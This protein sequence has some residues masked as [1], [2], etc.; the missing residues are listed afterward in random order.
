MYVAAGFGTVILLLISIVVLW[1][2]N[3]HIREQHFQRS[4]QHASEYRAVSAMIY[5]AHLRAIT[6]YKMTTLRDPFEVDETY[7]EFQ[8]WG[9]NL[10]K[11]RDFL[12]SSTFD[13]EEKAIWDKVRG[14]LNRGYES[15]YQVI[16]LINSGDFIAASNLISSRVSPIQDELQSKLDELLAVKT[17]RLAQAK[18]KS[19]ALD[20]T[21]D[22][23]IYLLSLTCVALCILTVIFTRRTANTEMALAAQGYR[24]RSLYE[25]ASHSRAS[26]D[27]QIDGTLRV[28][29]ELFGL[30]IGKLCKIDENTQRNKMINVVVPKNMTTILKKNMDVP[31]EK[32]F[33]SIPFQENRIVLIDNIA[34]SNYKAYPCVEFANLG[35]YIAAPVYVFGKKYGTI[36]FSSFKSK[37]KRFGDDDHDLLYLIGKFV[38]V[39]LETKLSQEMEIAKLA[40]EKANSTKSRFL[41]NM[42][43]ELRTP[44]NAIIG[45]SELLLSDA[46]VGDDNT[47]QDIQKINKAGYHLLHLVNNVLDISKV[48]AGKMTVEPEEFKLYELIGN[49]SDIMTPLIHENNNK[50]VV[51]CEAEVMA[52]YTDKQKLKQILLNLLSNSA[53]FTE[54]GEIRVS[55]EKNHSASDDKIAIAISDTGIGM[56]KEVQNKIFEEFT[57][58]TTNKLSHHS[59]TG[60]GLSICRTF[61]QLLGGDISVESVPGEGSRFVAIIQQ[62]YVPADDIGGLENTG[63]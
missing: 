10:M 24:I 9:E 20:Q 40:A 4:E 19:K 16:R 33:C 6:L 32:T 11:Q 43:H 18:L 31:L 30:E 15:Q 62:R 47:I 8:K 22:W 12:A 59:G 34:T 53:K 46:V 57:Q 60:L 48:E 58:D 35:C 52:L 37:P 7:L 41:S 49:I 38:S 3:E 36:N 56:S 61:C 27:D 21:I 13:D 29:C 25:V 42:S 55:V 50:L 54:N 45:Y 5:F 63:T 2:Y 28:G 23:F 26:F 39:I 14:I 17:T 51:Q 44:L 1:K